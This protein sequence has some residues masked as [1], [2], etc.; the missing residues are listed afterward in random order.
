MTQQLGRP[1]TLECPQRTV[2]HEKQKADRWA[3]AP[4]AH[5][6]EALP[7]RGGGEQ[8]WGPPGPGRPRWTWGR[9]TQ[10]ARVQGA[11]CWRGAGCAPR[12]L[13]RLLEGCAP[14]SAAESMQTQGNLPRPEKDPKGRNRATPDAKSQKTADCPCPQQPGWV[15]S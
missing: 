5:Y 9:G 13:Q 1:L 15:T 14:G 7:G 2:T 12:E 10:A 6:P 4:P 3:A 8:P 11:E